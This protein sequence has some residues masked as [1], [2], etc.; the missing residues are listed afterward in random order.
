M[1]DEQRAVADRHAREDLLHHRL[2][3]TALMDVLSST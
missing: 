2:F 3:S 1:L